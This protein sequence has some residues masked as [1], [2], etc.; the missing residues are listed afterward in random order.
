M[1]QSVPPEIARSLPLQSDVTRE[2]LYAPFSAVPPSTTTEAVR[3]VIAP[4]TPAGPAGPAAPAAPAGPAGPC[5]PTGPAGSWPGAKS[6]RSS[7]RAATFVEFTALFLI[8]GLDTAPSFSCGV[9]TLFL[10]SCVAAAMPVPPSAT[11]N[12]RHATTIAGEGRRKS[13]LMSYPFLEACPARLPPR[14]ADSWRRSDLL[15]F[16]Y[17]DQHRLVILARSTARSAIDVSLESVDEPKTAPLQDLRVEI[18]TIVDDDD[19]RSIGLE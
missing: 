7:D 4:I 19:H 17:R 1:L 18:A 14:S 6:E 2:L 11:S 3:S 15:R 9:P 13:F 8:L 10:A 16:P 5:G 12:A